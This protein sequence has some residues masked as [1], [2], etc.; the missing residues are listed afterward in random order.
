MRPPRVFRLY[1]IMVNPYCDVNIAGVVACLSV[2][3]SVRLSLLCR[4]RRRRDRRRCCEN[5]SINATRARA[6]MESE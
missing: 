6:A 1:I 5:R 3:P 2:R 4:R